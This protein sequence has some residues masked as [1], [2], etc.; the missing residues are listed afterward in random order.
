MAT[1]VASPTTRLGTPAA[2]A[3]F[4]VANEPP[5]RPGSGQAS[6]TE[7]KERLNKTL[8]SL[9]GGKIGSIEQLPY[10]RMGGR[11]QEL[12]AQLNR[13]V[14]AAS[15]GRIQSWQAL[16]S[17]DG[18]RVLAAQAAKPG[19]PGVPASNLTVDAHDE[20]KKSLGVALA[21]LSGGKVRSLEQLQAYKGPDRAGLE[22]RLNQ[23]VTKA[24][25]GQVR[26]YKDLLDK[27]KSQGDAGKP[28]YNPAAALTYAAT[29]TVVAYNILR[30]AGLSV[31][32]AATK[33]PGSFARS[34]IT[35]S[36]AQIPTNI[37]DP[38]LQ[39][40]YKGGIG[41]LLTLGT[42]AIA[43]KVHPS[44][45]LSP[46]MNWS[47][48]VAAFTT[49][50][51]VVGL[52][53]LQQRGY[54]GGLP[55]DN[56]KD[57]GQW[58]QKYAPPSVAISAGLTPPVLL[59]SVV[60]AARNGSGM[61]PQQ[62]AVNAA[63]TLVFPFLQNLLANA[64]VNPP[65]GASLDAS[66]FPPGTVDKLKA[67]ASA[68]GQM[69]LY[70]MSDKIWNVINSF[71]KPPPAAGTAA[72]KWSFGA[73]AHAAAWITGV[74]EAVGV[75]ATGVSLIGRNTNNV[76]EARQA[77]GEIDKLL[78]H[79]F[80]FM[81]PVTPG[82]TDHEANQLRS[83]RINALEASRD[84]ILKEHPELRSEYFKRNPEVGRQFYEKY[85]ELRPKGSSSR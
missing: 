60:H 83:D 47:M 24:S 61:T 45:A 32:D 27:A 28:G 29:G 7:I 73:S 51:A 17:A 25:S 43:G 5:L 82:L 34:L 15:G 14:R 36:I 30:S 11:F 79:P 21:Q 16:L 48:V 31:R 8:S 4:L 77:L 22:A 69:G 20:V 78:Q 18:R 81:G 68:L 55:P 62:L 49:A 12:E 3:P 63:V 80:T 57:W 35:A 85:P 6:T 56:P 50:G 71:G 44:A 66:K 70:V 10:Y 19:S 2:D 41:A 38:F 84:N 40:T 52:K 75:L 33:L 53:E 74:T 37:K 64:I 58:F 39:V 46:A 59:G 67:A 26:S 9:T 13:E 54:L 23:E 72:A 65:K 42:N 76:A 1:L